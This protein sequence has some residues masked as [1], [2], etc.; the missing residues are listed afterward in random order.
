MGNYVLSSLG[1][2][3]TKLVMKF[4]ENYEMSKPANIGSIMPNLAFLIL[5]R[6]CIYPSLTSDL[7]NRPLFYSAENSPFLVGNKALKLS[8]LACSMAFFCSF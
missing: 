7:Q 8:S 1:P 4:M 5:V 3:K 2:R 6:L